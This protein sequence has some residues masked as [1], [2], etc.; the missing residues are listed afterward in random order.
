[1]DLYPCHLYKDREYS[2]V[3]K[4]KDPCRGNLQFDKFKISCSI[5]H[6]NMLNK[7][8]MLV[9][10][11]LV[12]LETRPYQQWLLTYV[13]Y[14]GMSAFSVVC[15]FIKRCFGLCWNC[16]TTRQDLDNIKF[17]GQYNDFFL[18]QKTSVILLTTWVKERWG[19]TFLLRISDLCLYLRSY[20]VIRIPIYRLNNLAEP[21]K[22]KEI[23]IL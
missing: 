18:I 16:H 5:K 12:K 21:V 1:M 4:G 8:S 6:R 20:S 22:L 19:K 15:R 2:L 13:L 23:I 14:L 10:Y 9:E 17:R 3:H 7:V 11:Q